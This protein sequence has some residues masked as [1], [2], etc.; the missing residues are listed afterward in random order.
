[1]GWAVRTK[2]WAAIFWIGGEGFIVKGLDPDE[3]LAEKGVVDKLER[4]PD[5]RSMVKKAKQA[6]FKMTK[7]LF[8]KSET[9]FT[10]NLLDFFEMGK[11]EKIYPYNELIM[12]NFTIQRV[13][14]SSQYG[15][16]DIKREIGEYMSDEEIEAGALSINE[17][18]SYTHLTLPT[19]A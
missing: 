7:D 19:K 13:I 4:H 2:E 6:L 1:M 15:S 8:D 18:V 14:Y 3:S 10:D 16:E 17:S 12:D 11:E 9:Y 5:G